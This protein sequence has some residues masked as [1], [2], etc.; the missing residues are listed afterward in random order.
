MC[1]IE[2]SHRE[3]WSGPDGFHLTSD[4]RS[5]YPDG[6]EE[7]PYQGFDIPG[8]VPLFTEP[9]DMIIF[10]HRTYHGA[11]P[12][13]LD[14]VRLSC[15]IGFRDR[16]HRIDVPWEIPD[17]GKRFLDLLPSHLEHYVDGYTSINTRWR[18]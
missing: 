8:M 1:V 7:R 4:R 14:E 18:G 10:A 16:N 15:A 6:E 17:G 11:F 5:F 12:N 2:D 13:R 9:G 3:N